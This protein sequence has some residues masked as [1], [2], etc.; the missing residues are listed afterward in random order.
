MKA[1]SRPRPTWSV[2]L[3]CE[4]YISE[5][6]SRAVN[7]YVY[8]APGGIGFWVTNGTPSWKKSS[9]WTPWKWTPVVSWRLLVKIARTRSPWL[10]R[11][12]GPG[13]CS[14]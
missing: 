13:H 3:W 4:W 1:P 8:V 7:S 5:P 10:T 9:N 12:V 2:A 14:L 6:A 11:I